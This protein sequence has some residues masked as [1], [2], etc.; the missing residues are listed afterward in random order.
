M[1]VYENVVGSRG[2]AVTLLSKYEVGSRYL[3]QGYTS[4]YR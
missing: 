3:G 1:K 4:V 2:V